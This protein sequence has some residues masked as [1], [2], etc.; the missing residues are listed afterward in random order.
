MSTA[1]VVLAAGAGSRFAGNRHKLLAP[2]RDTTV[3]A[4]A[5]GA[6]IDAGLDAVFVV[7]GA[8]PLPVPDVV[9]VV[10]NPD[11]VNGQATSLAAGIAA[12]QAAGHDTVVI[13]LGDQPLVSAQAWRDVAAETTTPIAV[14]SFGGKR[15]P[16][17]RLASEMWELLP[18]A[19][20]VG[21]RDLLRRRPELVTEVPCT[22]DPADID[23]VEDLARWS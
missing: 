3:A 4:A 14:A 16:P 11:W 9:V 23:T 20:D 15:R 8:V 18:A 7:I 6:A 22:G 17:V 2:F 5:I 19:G 10:P 12:A 1:A 13:G 21:A